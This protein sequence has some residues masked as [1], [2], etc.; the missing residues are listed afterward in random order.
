MSELNNSGVL[1]LISRVWIE[2]MELNGYA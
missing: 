1:V 2:W